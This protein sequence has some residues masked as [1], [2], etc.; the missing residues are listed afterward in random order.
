MEKLKQH[1]EK[2]VLGALLLGFVLSLVYLLQMVDSARKVTA[3]DLKF[4][5]PARKYNVQ[6]FGEQKYNIDYV[7]GTRAAWDARQDNSQMGFTAE[8]SVPMKALRCENAEC[9]KIIPWDMAKKLKCP[10]CHGELG[11]PGNPPDYETQVAKMDTDGDGMPDRYES[12]MGLNP[13]DPT[14]ADKD[15][16][17]DGFSN[18]YEFLVKTDPTDNRSFPGLDKC[19]YLYR[20]TKKTMPLMLNGVTQVDPKNKKTW[21]INLTINNMREAKMLGD[22]FDVGKTKYQILDVEYR[23]R[24]R[25]DASVTV[26]DDASLVTIVP[27]VKNKPDMKRKMVL[28]VNKRNYENDHIVQIRDVRTPTKRPYRLELNGTFTVVSEDGHKVVFQLIS[29]NAEKEQVEL[30]N[31]ETENRFLLEKHMRVPRNAYVKA[32]ESRSEQPQQRTAPSRSGRRRVRN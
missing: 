22:T 11:D 23:T 5:A 26:G 19:L 2:I 6:N 1:Y 24:D 25:Q 27:V 8:L 30:L 4:T 16:D 13:L 20:L 10:F 29:A 18:L 3:D 14:D 31:T 15:Q 12:K 21:D 32:G 28:E 7:L 17:N 9:R